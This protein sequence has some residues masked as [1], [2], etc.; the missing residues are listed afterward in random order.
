MVY[1]QDREVV[2][3]NEQGGKRKQVEK[4]KRGKRRRREKDIFVVPRFLEADDV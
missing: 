2:L 4:E 1:S 3:G